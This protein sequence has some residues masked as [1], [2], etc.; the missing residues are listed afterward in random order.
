MP[1]NDLEVFE[2]LISNKETP[3]EIDYLTYALFASKKKSWVEHFEKHNGK[4]P[5]Q[6]EIDGWISQLPDSEYESMRYDAAQYF[7]I[8]SREYLADQIEEQKRQAVGQSILAEITA[9][10]ASILAEV[11]QFTSPWKHFGIALGMAII[12]PVFLGG[13]IFL[14]TLFDSSVHVNISKQETPPASPTF[15]K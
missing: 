9:A 5:A 12:A 3:L 4:R 15:N 10:N 14:Y 13:L 8:A 2:H 11:K 6:A 1:A 7:E